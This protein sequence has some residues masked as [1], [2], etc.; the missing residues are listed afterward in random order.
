M[1]IGGVAL[2]ESAGIGK[3][4]AS[5]S[6]AH[7]RDAAS[8]WA[9]PASGWKQIARRTWTE[10]GT[11]NIGLIAAGV[12]FYGFLAM[13]PLL[14]ALVLSYGLIA[15]PATVMANINA[16][17]SVMPAEAAKLIGEQLL[18]V[19][20]TSGGKK[21]FGLLIALVIS[22][23]G[24]MNAASAIVT[25]LNIA[26]EEKE[27][28]GFF[29]LYLLSLL[30][31]LVGIVSIIAAMLSVAVL[32]YLGSLLPSLPGPVLA[33]GKIGSYVLMA[34]AGAAAAASLYRYGPARTHA[35]WTW[36]TPGSLLT[37]TLWLVI[38]LGFGIYV[39]NFGNYDATY[40][41]LGAVVVLL[42]WF[43]LS[44]Y[45]LLLGAELNSEIERQ[46]ACDTTVGPAKP[47]GARG[48]KMADAVAGD[49][50]VAPAAPPTLAPPQPGDRPSAAIA[51]RAAPMRD[52]V[53]MRAG[54]RVARF[55]GLPRVTMLP[56]LLTTGGLMLL[57]KRGRARFGIALLA[58]GGA[59]AWHAR[60]QRGPAR[61]TTRALPDAVEKS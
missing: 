48:A 11:D 33:L 17:A 36:L 44:A 43:Y 38:T 46:T 16:L 10:A 31:T 27:K 15:S 59:L 57:R 25:A 26:Y 45:V 28:R 23:Y 1:V 55:A 42:T 6:A 12:A 2:G 29:A 7:G 52:F 19:V 61:E 54:G 30:I 14:G 37:A 60:D 35:R 41:S 4:Y 51:P 56:S 24:A 3:V 47:P 50:P 5:A 21:G 32:G 39:A 8:P 49:P 18:N 53:A 58:G 34:L 22:L 9:I 13:V 40:G 20:T